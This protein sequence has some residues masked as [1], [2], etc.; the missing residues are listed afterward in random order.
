VLRY[1]LPSFATLVALGVGGA[2]APPP[3]LRI[4]VLEARAP[5][6]ENPLAAPCPEGALPDG[7][8]DV[9]V[10]LPRP[11]DEGEPE[12]ESAANGH[13][14]RGGR[15]QVYEEIPRR[16]DRPADYDRYRYPVP[17]GIPGGHSVV[18]GFDLDKP[19]QDQRRG[20]TLH[21][22]GH[23]GVDLPGARGTPIHLVAL[24]R[25][26]G[27]AEVLY[28]GPLFGTSVITRQTVREGGR[29]RDYVVIF[30]HMDSVAPGVAVGRALTEGDAVGAVGDTGSPEL[31]HLHWEARRVRD[32]VDVQQKAKAGGAALLADDVSV[33]CDPRNVLPLR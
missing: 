21:A 18:S 13:H 17:P 30:G 14:A 26:Q 19:D 22:V 9:C 25:Q 28:V 10:H 5:T 11:G 16:P 20:R 27:D 23:G 12:R 32:G 2:A 15:W 29:A 4:P 1:A 6:R 31:V 7:E 33:V 8:S 3:P 24:E